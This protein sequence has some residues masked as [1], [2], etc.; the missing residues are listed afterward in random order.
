MLVNRIYFI[1]ITF[2][3]MISLSFLI[4]NTVVA[5]IITFAVVMIGYIIISLMRNK[6]R[7]SLLEEE[8][9]PQAF[10]EATERQRKITGRNPKMN[11]LLNIDRSAGLILNGEFEK[12]KDTLLSVDKSYLSE[13]NGSLF[14]YNVN[15]ISCHYELGENE[16]AERLFEKEMPLLSPTNK[17]MKLSIK[18]LNADRLLRL[19]RFEESEI[20]FKR[21]LEEKISKR[22]ELSIL[23]SLAQI[24]EHKGNLKDAIYKYDE[25]SNNGN[26]L[27]IAEQSRKKL[28]ELK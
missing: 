27:W 14:V 2:I 6:N 18:L 25:V 24:D 9:D 7:V 26:K 23:H 8:C 17:R 3:I 19:K 28:T 4:E 11:T 16:S 15:L 1:V 12:A 22:V 10:L 13:K 20:E 5:G 21:L